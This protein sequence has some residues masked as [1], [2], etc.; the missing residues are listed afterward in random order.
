M[1]ERGP[2][3]CHSCRLHLRDADVDDLAPHGFQG[4]QCP[5]TGVHDA[6]VR[7]FKPLQQEMPTTRI[8]LSP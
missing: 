4:I 6:C 8:D 7:I 5:V 2:H 3:V 1:G